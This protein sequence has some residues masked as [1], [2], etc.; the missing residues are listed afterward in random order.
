MRRL[1]WCVAIAALLAA[2]SCKRRDRVVV[3]ATQEE[4]QVLASVVHVADPRTATQLARGFYDVEGNS[5]RW[6]AGKFAVTLRPPAGAAQKGATLSFKFAFPDAVFAKTGPIT[7]TAN[8][9][10]AGLTPETY[11]KPG[12]QTYTRDVP[13]TALGRDAVTVEFALD[14]SLPPSAADQ[15]ELGVIATSIGFEAK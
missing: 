12:E 4:G 7:V 3:E 13:A 8:V 11:A 10:G 1:T 9:G 15:R 6:T 14:K 5:W 2:P